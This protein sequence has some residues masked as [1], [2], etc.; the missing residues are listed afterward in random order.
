MFA[1]KNSKKHI[2]YYSEDEPPTKKL[3]SDGDL[4]IK[5]LYEKQTNTKVDLKEWV[6]IYLSVFEFNSFIS[7]RLHN[8]NNF[9]KCTEF[10]PLTSYVKGSNSLQNF[11]AIVEQ[12]DQ[13]E[14][15]KAAGV[16][17]DDI[18]LFFDSKKGAEYL[19]ETHKNLERSILEEK[20]K[21]IERKIEEYCRKHDCDEDKRNCTSRHK[22]EFALSVKPN[23]TETKLLQFALNNEKR[24]ST[25]I[26]YPMDSI[27][28]IEKQ[29]FG[30]IERLNLNKIRK[31]ARNLQNKVAKV[32]INMIEENCPKKKS[33]ECDFSVNSKW[34]VKESVIS[35]TSTS[36]MAKEYTCKPQKLYTIEDGRIVQLDTT[37]QSINTFNVHSRER[38][39]L[40]EIKKDPKFANYEEGEE[41]R[42][43]LKMFSLRNCNFTLNCR[44]CT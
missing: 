4:L 21:C 22:T 44:C 39:N 32:G 42:V 19:K 5:E 33:S 7:F 23:S 25:S 29:Y 35:V 17:S 16:T 28:E 43:R 2:A 15:L 9:E 14:I 20:L 12:S 26:P 18:K 13:I 10:V 27:K 6:F 36:K 8:S 37:N 31:K 38:I 3:I 34:D 24:C 40:E 11:Q 30:N 41:S 1:I